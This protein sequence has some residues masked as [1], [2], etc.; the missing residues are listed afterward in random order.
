M[1]RQALLGAAAG[2][3]GTVALNVAT[4]ADMVI[5]GRAASSVPA[6]L[7]GTLADKVGIDL[8]ADGDGT[9]DETAEHRRTGLGALMG[10]VIGLG[11]GTAY[12]M[13]RPHMQDVPLPASG[14]GLA[15]IAMVASDV[16]ATVLGVTDP[17]TWS[18]TS[19]ALD[20][21]FHLAYGLTTVI[22]YDAFQ[23]RDGK[24]YY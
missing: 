19:W 11:T 21:G 9:A 1:L 15:I 3:V 14:L 4:Y 23:W 22:A 10:Y 5:R 2:A 6:E 7:A 24:I 13:L 18:R 8:S 12:G 16:P 17:T 20:F